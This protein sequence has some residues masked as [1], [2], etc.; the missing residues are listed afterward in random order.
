MLRVDDGERREA[1]E[2]NERF[3]RT[4]EQNVATI[5]F[6]CLMFLLSPEV[7]FRVDAAHT[8]F[9]LANAFGKK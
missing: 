1:E 7:T 6:W 4:H 9:A 5:A 2:G 3:R 8:I